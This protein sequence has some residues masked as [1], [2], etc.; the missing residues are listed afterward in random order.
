MKQKSYI[1]SSLLYIS[2]VTYICILVKL[3][4]LKA[5]A[6]QGINLIPFRF[7]QD[8][9]IHN[10]TLGLSNVIGNVVMFIPMG[11]YITMQNR[12]TPVQNNILYIAFISL[13]VEILQYLFK[14][15]ITD[16]DDLLLNTLGG[17]LGII[18]YKILQNRY[19]EKAKDIVA[20]GS[21]LIG[22][23]FIT[24][25]AC[26]YYGVFGFRIRL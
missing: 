11:V 24:L 3:L 12:K 5:S 16:I 13:S 25:Y 19:R 7:I 21:L 17:F 26:L 22:I 2:I 1:L 18:F 6:L 8:Y 20:I 9:V 4:F 23:A 15:G 10:G 14:V